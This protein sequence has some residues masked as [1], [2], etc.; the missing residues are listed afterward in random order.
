[1]ASRPIPPASK[2]IWLYRGQRKDS[3]EVGAK[4]YRGL[5]ERREREVEL[6]SRADD[7][8]QVGH[9]IADRLGFT[10]EDAM[11]VAQHFSA[12]E[13][14][15][16]PTWLVDFSRD[17]WV[18]LFFATDGGETGDLGIVWSIMPSEYNR[19][20]A[21]AGN[22]IGP[23]QL[24][25]PRGV[26]RIDNQ[27]G[28]FVIAGLPQIFDQCVAFGWETRFRQHTGLVFE[29]PALGI[30]RRTIYPPDDP[31]RGVLAEV[32]A[33]AVDCG[34]GSG[35]KLCAVSPAVF[36]DPFEPTT[37]EG[38]LTC[39][40]NEF[41]ADRVGESGRVGV[42]E[43]S[44]DLARFHARLHS[45]AYAGRLP[46]VV[47]RSL[48]RLRDAFETLYFQASWGE[49]ASLRQAIKK[50]YVNHMLWAEDHVTVLLEALNETLGP[51]T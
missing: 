44:A 51:S 30:S 1:M 33:A 16:T 5:P 46:N 38:L 49:P 50:S 47:S 14:L 35:T 10:F 45:P 28:V 40:L 13:I 42:R 34:C 9:A 19:L 32:R 39:W 17:P 15:A 22:P 12:A 36:T 29:D 4:I 8:C 25:V 23:L 3:W 7:A 24:V 26:L 18:G 20:T 37:Y 41:Q 48:N 2:G 6:R 11:A 21:G 43:A 31:L 27:A